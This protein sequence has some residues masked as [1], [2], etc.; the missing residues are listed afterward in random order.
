MD[1]KDRGVT[2]LRRIFG[3]PSNPNFLPLTLALSKFGWVDKKNALSHILS[4]FRRY[5]LKFAFCV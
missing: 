3:F 2:A 1:V 5:E 4:N